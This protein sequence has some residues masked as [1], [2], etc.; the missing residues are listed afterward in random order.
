[1]WVVY[2][3]AFPNGKVYIG[4][5]GQ[6]AYKRW[7]YGNGYSTTI[8]RNAINKYGWENIK[9]E[10][11]FENL[12]KEEAEKKEIEL[13][14][15]FR[16]NQFEYGYNLA[17]GGAVNC[18]YKHSAEFRER[19]S[20]RQLGKPSTRKDYHPSE[21]TKKKLSE[22]NKG[23]KLSQETKAKMSA[24]RKNGKVWNATPVINLDTNEIFMSQRVA[25]QRYN[26]N[27]KNIY[28]VLKG[29]RRTAGGY[30][31]AYYNPSGN[32]CFTFTE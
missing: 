18:G 6:K 19:I 1:M 10:I 23:K 16:S 29:K 9:H 4:I 5:T 25:G 3:H 15:L 26:F 7:K 2:K 8:M 17:S 31:W 28:L 27:Y 20:K 21:E 12:T 14:E 11:L 13:I 32:L 24:S 30:R 22:L